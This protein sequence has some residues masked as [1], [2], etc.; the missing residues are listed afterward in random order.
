MQ[1]AGE[2]VGAAPFLVEFSASMEARKYEFNHGRFF[3][4]V[5]ANW[6][7]S[8]VVF[9]GYAAVRVQGDLNMFTKASQGLVGRIIENFLNDVKRML[10]SGIHARA[11][12]HGFKAFQHPNR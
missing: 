3:F 2:G 5:Q 8:P 11:L 9:N 6:D 12:A 10:C 7:A 1:T 4:G